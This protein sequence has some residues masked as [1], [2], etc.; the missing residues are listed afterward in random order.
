MLPI[1]RVD[2]PYLPLKTTTTKEVSTKGMTISTK[3]NKESE[4]VV[5]HCLLY[6]VILSVSVLQLKIC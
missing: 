1:L 2:F 6:F 4:S 3:P 5:A